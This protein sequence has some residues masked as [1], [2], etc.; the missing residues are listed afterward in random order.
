MDSINMTDNLPLA[1]P[2]RVEIAE[3][4]FSEYKTISPEEWAAR[5]AH[6]VGC[7]SFDEYRY[8]NIEL[9]NWIHRLH[10]IF[11]IPGEIEK[12]RKQY[13]NESERRAIEEELNDPH[14]GL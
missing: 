3:R 8:E 2:G 12:Y 4:L 13:L 11:R 6:T 1:D 9:H 10:A 5:Y 7:S 14:D